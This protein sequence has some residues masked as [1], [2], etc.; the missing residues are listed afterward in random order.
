MAWD[1]RRELL[2][3]CLIPLIPLSLYVVVLTEAW[4]CLIG[5]HEKPFRA[6]VGVGSKVLAECS[7]GVFGRYKGVHARLWL[8]F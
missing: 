5:D 1:V 4:V 6:S 8:E 7:T 3:Q 2:L